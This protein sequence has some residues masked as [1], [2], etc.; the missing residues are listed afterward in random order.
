[1]KDS[2]QPRLPNRQTPFSDAFVAFIPTDWAPYPA[3][4]PAR[5]PAA[6]HTA[7]RRDAVSAAHPGERVVVPAGTLKVRSNDTDYPFRPHSAFAHLTG[8]GADREPDAVLVLDPIRPDTDADA[9][10]DDAT[11]D[12]A[13][14]SGAGAA[15][16]HVATL[17][18]KPRTPRTEPEFYADPRYGE[19]WVGQRES[20][21]E[22]EA[23]TGLPCR[24][25]AELPAALSTHL[26]TVPVRIVRDVDDRLTTLLDELR[27][28]NGAAFDA[29]VDD[30]LTTMLSELRLIKDDFE[31][32]ELQRACDATASGFEAVVRDFPTAVARGRGERWCEGVFALHARHLG[33]D[34]GYGS[35]CA[36]GDHANTLHWIRNDGDLVDGDLVL[37]DMGVEVDSL[38][39]ADITRTLPVNGRFTTAQRKVYDAVLAAQQAGID[40]ARPGAPFAAVHQAAIRVVAEHL[41]AWGILPVDADESLDAVTGGHHRRWM[42][43]GTSHHLGLDVHDCAQARTEFYREGTLRPGM[44]ITVEPGIYF[45][46]TDLLVPKEFR[47]IGVRIEDDIVITEDGN[48]ILSD[49]LPRDADAVEAWMAGLRGGDGSPGGS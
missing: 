7:A 25:L 26:D 48:R 2:R 40:A 10:T 17:Y 8:L 46:S 29:D 49:K 11:A 21:A 15:S 32:A 33:N 9:A 36:A 13:E 45:K 20:L 1:M 19:M 31:I 34:V 27:R 38:Y 6:E 41:A 42:V 28:T 30:E 24:S 37:L 23:M 47:G 44:V 35:I 4:L 39:T 18:F 14:A 12:A 43:H 16:G 3:E 5:L 22:M